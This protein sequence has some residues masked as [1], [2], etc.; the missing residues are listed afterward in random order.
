MSEEGTDREVIG[1]L[2]WNSGWQ[3]SGLA[4]VTPMEGRDP[5]SKRLRGQAAEVAL[6]RRVNEQHGRH[7]SGYFQND[8]GGSPEKR[9]LKSLKLP[10]GIK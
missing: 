1:R 8:P 3:K 2:P 9:M 4:W 5:Q 10:E 7:R 6:S